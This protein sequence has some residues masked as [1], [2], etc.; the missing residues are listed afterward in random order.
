MCGSTLSVAG[1]PYRSST[2]PVQR[3]QPLGRI[4]EG[5][6]GRSWSRSTTAE[7]IRDAADEGLV[8]WTGKDANAAR[9]AANVRRRVATLTDDVAQLTIILD[10]AKT[11]MEAARHLVI[12]FMATFMEW[13]ICTWCR[14]WPPLC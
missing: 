14:R 13:P 6:Y 5:N 3:R 11:V 8:G 1:S 2:R 9:A 7:E 4:W 10:L 12:S